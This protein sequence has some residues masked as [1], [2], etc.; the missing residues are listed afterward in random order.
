VR[1]IASSESSLPLWEIGLIVIA[2]GLLVVGIVVIVAL[3]R[4][5]NNNTNKKK[6]TSN[7]KQHE[8]GKIQAHQQQVFLLIEIN[9]VMTQID[10]PEFDSARDPANEYAAICFAQPDN[11]V[12]VEKASKHSF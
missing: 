10:R 6:T 2:V 7:D 9:I 4:R 5:R 3:R 11:D 1:Q 12:S 8:N